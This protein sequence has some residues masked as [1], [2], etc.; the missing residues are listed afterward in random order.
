MQRAVKAALEDMLGETLDDSRRAIDGCS[1]PTYAA[2]LRGL[3]RAFARFASGIG[4]SPERAKAAQRI[5]QAVRKN[6]FYVAGS[7]RFDFEF[8]TRFG[9]KVFT[10]TG[11]EGVFCAALPHEGLG[12]AV[13]ADDGAGRAAEVMIASLIMR[14]G[15]FDEAERAAA[16]RF[17]RPKL[18]NWRGIEV[19]VCGPQGRWRSEAS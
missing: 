17:V 16:E 13:K 18:T 9:A 6:P 11:A 15:E 19:G 10:K 2:S 1:I 12:L 8:M 7:G 5:R 3:A 14:F 4:V